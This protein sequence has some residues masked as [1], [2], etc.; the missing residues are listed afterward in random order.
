MSLHCP[1]CGFEIAAPRDRRAHLWRTRVRLYGM[2]A[3]DEPIADSDPELSPDLPGATV[4]NGLQSLPAD[5]AEM[6]TAYHGEPCEG[7]DTATLRHRLK[8][9]YPTLSRRGGNAVW[10][11]A[12]EA[13]GKKYMARVDIRR[14]TETC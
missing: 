9:L 14:E 1:S 13:A 7:M 8:S 5:L 10:R 12:Y 2:D 3:A 4:I 11:L 6:V